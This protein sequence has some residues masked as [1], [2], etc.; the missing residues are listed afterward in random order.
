[1]LTLQAIADSIPGAKLIGPEDLVISGYSTDT[2][3]ID[4]GS[5]FFA[6]RGERFDAHDFIE[7][8][9]QQ[10][11]AAIVTEKPL[12]AQIP[13]ILVPDS[14]T[15]LGDTAKA[16]RKRF[17]IPVIAVTGSNGKTTVTQMLA[18]ILAEASG[19]DRRLATQGNLNNDIGLPL[20][21][22]R[23]RP[24]HERAVV[25]LG[26]NHPGEIAYLAA[27]AS[28][29]VALVNNAQREHQE[30]MGTVE[31]T[32]HE[33]GSAISALPQDGT[34]VYPADDE[35]APIWRNLAGNREIFDFGFDRPARMR[36]AFDQ[37]EKGMTLTLE[38]KEGV[39]KA[40]LA[41]TGA[42]NA[43]NAAAAASAALAAGIS[44]VHIQ[45]GLERFRP[46]AG[47]GVILLSREGATLIDDSYNA[48]PDSVLAA[49]DL[50]SSRS[51]PSYL[52]LGD[53]GEVGEKGPEFHA[54]IGAY[55]KM[56][57]INGLLTHGH[58]ARHSSEAFQGTDAQHFDAIEDLIARAQT[59]A[60]PESILLIKG[61]R[62]MKM[63][64]VIAALT[65]NAALPH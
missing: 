64:R 37:E 4:P 19:E 60:T 48:N 1:M 11:A 44:L 21:L 33:N 5:L 12:D 32:A 47:R 20:T 16:W 30:F 41:L 13:H 38:T 51:G 59:L 17:A 10:G 55:A 39:I 35:C 43:H 31:A 45:Q 42:H 9:L 28:P 3:K 7:Q 63:E 54:E 62:F 27:I 8:A 56:R 34:A 26:M 2:R 24:H 18:S 46:V 15:A 50:L 29:T 25:E 23:M 57:G 65:G 40:R 36:A 14:R 61:S 58:L 53:M 6:L 49:I 52:I 22:F